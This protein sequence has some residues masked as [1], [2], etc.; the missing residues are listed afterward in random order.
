MLRKT[1]FA[2]VLVASTLSVSSVASATDF[3]NGLAQPHLVEGTKF[4][5]FRTAILNGAASENINFGFN[6]TVITWGCG[7]ECQSGV[8]INRDNGNI[9]ELPVAAYGY[10]FRTECNLLI[11]N[12]NPNEYLTSS[13]LMGTGELPSWLFR[14]MYTL[15]NGYF[16]K[17]LKDKAEPGTITNEQAFGKYYIVTKNSD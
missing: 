16:V 1:L 10:D 2:V 12:P 17:V 13:D 5:K 11:V 15:K 14:E 4:W 3:V 6:E 8:I 9:T 7:T